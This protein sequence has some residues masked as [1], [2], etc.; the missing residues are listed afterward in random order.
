MRWCLF[1][2][3]ILG[4]PNSKSDPPPEEDEPSV[5]PPR[6]E[7][8]PVFD[9]ER[10][11]G[12]PSDDRIT[13]V[14][15]VHEDGGY[16][17]VEPVP[18]VRVVYRVTLRVPGVLGNRPDTFPSP[19][20]E[21]HVD[22][23][24]ERLRARFVGSGWPIEAGSEVRLRSDYDGVYVFDAEGGRPLTAG[25]LA[26]WFQ[27][28]SMT[29]THNPSV[30]ILPALGRREGP[31]ALVCAFLAELSRQARDGMIRR[32]GTIGA[33]TR[34][35]IGPW[36]ADR[37]AELPVN[38]PRSSLRADERSP[39]RIPVDAR[40]RAFYAPDALRRLEPDQ[41]SGPEQVGHDDP[42]LDPPE[43]LRVRNELSVRTLVTVRGVAVGWVDP[44]AE[45]HFS[46]IPPG[47]YIVAGMRPFGTLGFRT[48]EVD[49][50]A[51]VRA[52]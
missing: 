37:T 50:P 48:R 25:F 40:S 19:T 2:I 7:R 36:L 29:D 13:L 52:R 27:G 3:F 22:V 9:P 6:D 28:G 18:S 51:F 12:P 24:E 31:G 26:E 11:V 8:A 47:R 45:A 33:P 38:L 42:S 49:L 4:C 20:A 30:G 41:R 1:A 17:G 16:A 15:A 46:G 32:C 35:R 14:P 5:L 39:P 23:S 43:G 10:N 44:D 21:L 34:F